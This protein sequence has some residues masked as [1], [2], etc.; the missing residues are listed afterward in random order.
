MTKIQ[1]RR[2]TSTNWS[3]NN[4]TP[5]SGEPCY[6]TD[7]GKF[8]IGNGTTPYNNLEYIGAGDLPDN[9][10]TQ[11]NTFNGASQLVQLDSSGKLPAIDGSQ[12]TNLPSSTPS[13][14]VT[15]DTE[16]TIAAVKKFQLAPYIN[17]INTLDGQKSI[18]Y[19]TNNT[20]NLGGT[21]TN[22]LTCNF[23]NTPTINNVNIATIND[24]PD[25]SSFASQAS[26]N[27]INTALNGI[28]FWKGTQSAYEG[29]ATKDENTLYIITGA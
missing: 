7:T 13:N 23:N 11:G 5:A 1:I 15:T 25:T 22:G 9:I 28:K 8:K 2:D 14:M 16:Q 19:V 26:V 10:T 12:L 21:S 6:E 20:L 29:I 17:A 27:S 24:I 4:P 3:T 18:Y